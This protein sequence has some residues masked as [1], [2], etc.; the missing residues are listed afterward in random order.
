[1]RTSS[2]FLSMTRNSTPIRMSKN[3]PSISGRKWS[4]FSTPTRRWKEKKPACMAWSGLTRQNRSS[5]T[6][7]DGTTSKSDKYY[8]R[9][10]KSLTPPVSEEVVPIAGNPAHKPEAERSRW[11][12]RG[13]GGI[14]A[15]SFLADLGHEVPTALLPAFLTSL[16]GAPAA[17][18]GLI[19]GIADGAAGLARFGGGALADEPARRRKVALGGYSATAILSALIGIATAAWQVGMFRIAAWIARGLRVPA[20]NALLADVVP[21]AAYGRAYGFERA[22]DNLGAIG[23]P[24]LA[25]GLVALVGLRDAILLSVVP[26]LLAA[27]A[28]F[29]AIRHAPR[30]RVREH[31]PIRLRIRPVIRGRLGRLL[32]A[33]GAF[34]VGNVAATLLILRAT[35][36]LEPGWG[37]TAATQLAL[38]LYVAYNL[39]ATIVSM[40]AGRVGDARGNTLVFA[41]GVVFFLLAYLS[42]AT[43]S[44]V[45]LV[46]SFVSAGVGIGCV[47][48]A[49]HAAVASFAPS[50][51]RGSAFGLLATVQSF[52]NLAAS[53]VAGLLWTAFSPSIAF[54]YVA[55][56][57]AIA[58]AGCLS[59]FRPRHL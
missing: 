30:L 3:S 7:S 47:E 31:Q 6:P 49:E 24:L 9:P 35:E 5:E 45:L 36:L 19:E 10:L 20:R 17:A 11:L 32:V 44:L 54:V 23:G 26:G 55:G 57:M 56:W 53:G 12:T 2:A 27:V 39:A 14:G 4:S 16:L 22:M 29:Y 37:Q 48:T 59:L 52:G 50:E 15:A 41:A 38:G 25:I 18:L 28:I 43:G 34:E 21:A 58:L 33:V 8:P 46:F 42:F 51:L 13:V 1:M 40:P